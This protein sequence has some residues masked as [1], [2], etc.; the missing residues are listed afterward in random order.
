M[1][2]KACV[3]SGRLSKLAGCGLLITA[4]S[5]VGCGKGAPGDPLGLG[6]PSV[7]GGESRPS[8]DLGDF[9][10]LGNGAAVIVGRVVSGPESAPVAGATVHVS[11]G[12]STTTD[13]DGWFTVE[14]VAGRGRAVLIAEHAGLAESIKQVSLESDGFTFVTISMAPARTSA[15]FDAA[16]GGEVTDGHGARAVFAPRGLATRD[17]RVVTGPVEVSL[18]PL[19]LAA[20]SQRVAFP[21]D[22]SG[23]RADGNIRL[24]SGLA[25]MAIVAKQ[26]SE[27]LTIASGR[28]A[29][30]SLP[31][32]AGAAPNAPASVPIWTLDPSSGEWREEGTATRVADAAA[33]GGYVYRTGVSHLS[34]FNGTQWLPSH[35]ISGVVTGLDNRGASSARV[36]LSDSTHN[37]TFSTLTD[38]FGRFAMDAPA[39]T[40]L[41]VVATSRTGDGISNDW[42]FTNDYH[43][44][45][46][47]THLDPYTCSSIGNLYLHPAPG[48]GSGTP[49]AILLPA[50]PASAWVKDGGGINALCAPP[51][52]FE[53]LFQTTGSTAI[54]AC[55]SNTAQCCTC[56]RRYR[57]YS[58][59]RMST[60]TA[61][62]RGR[63]YAATTPSRYS[64]PSMRIEL[65]LNGATVGKRVYAM[66]NRPNN[67]CVLPSEMPETILRS[68]SSFDIRLSTIAPGQQFDQVR[69]HLLGYG[70]DFATNGVAV[71]NMMLLPR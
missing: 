59:P 64:Q 37:A 15:Q 31:I 54:F 25:P 43:E 66:Q 63:F 58:V 45:N 39:G 71:Q 60:A 36:T 69:V 50:L 27:L 17:G 22:F 28:S 11:G 30:I 34:W 2:L 48:G 61:R 18:A 70:C 1:Q 10:E 14:N 68:N 13:A 21:G 19:D 24:L 53:A 32:S 33:P 44:D 5:G 40:L 67:N 42:S 3:R 55:R 47:G 23:R 4:M 12:S 9:E 7:D 6:P 29:T 8:L 56:T 41:H 46:I 57:T 26:G 49:N 52:P 20:P 38:D 65:L 62:I 35:C 16:V 51:N